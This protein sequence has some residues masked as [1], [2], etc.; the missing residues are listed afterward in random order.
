M[1][2]KQKRA[3]KKIAAIMHAGLQQF[4]KKEQ[5]KRLKEIAKITIKP[6]RLVS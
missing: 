3:A 4:S 1:Q 5:E 2:A 6:G